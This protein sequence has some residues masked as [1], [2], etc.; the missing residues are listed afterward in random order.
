ERT[1]AALLET[2]YEELHINSQSMMGL[3]GDEDKMEN[4]GSGGGFFESFKRVIRSR[5]Q[6]MDAMGLSNKKQHTVSTSHSGSFGH[7]Q[8]NPKPP[9]N[10]SN[11]SREKS[12]QEEVRTLQLPAE[13]RHRHREHPG[14]AGEARKSDWSPEDPGQRANRP[15]PRSQNLIT[16]PITAL[17][18]CPPQRTGWIRGLHRKPTGISPAP[19]SSASSFASVVEES[20]TPGRGRPRHGQRLLREHILT[21]VTPSY[22]AHGW[23]TVSRVPHTPMVGGE[24]QTPHT[25]R[26]KL[27]WKKPTQVQT[28]QRC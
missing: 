18:S 24:V 17:Q 20:E 7:N 12:D 1:R 15:P 11:C 25:Q 14:G 23:K 27:S 22:T 3:G 2:L 28:N 10:I 8:D 13:Q 4:G 21:S 6:S 19:S 9:G 16:R 5:S 26:L